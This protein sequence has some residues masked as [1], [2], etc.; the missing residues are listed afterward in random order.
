MRRDRL[1]TL[2][3]EE[4]GIDYWTTPKWKLGGI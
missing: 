2:D 3:A 4:P 1:L